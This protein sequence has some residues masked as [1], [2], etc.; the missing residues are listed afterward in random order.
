[1]APGT[2]W[3]VAAVNLVRYLHVTKVGYC[4]TCL[5][6]WW[7]LMKGFA[8]WEF[9]LFV[10]A[11]IGGCDGGSSGCGVGGVRVG[12]SKKHEVYWCSHGHLFVIKQ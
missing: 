6:N 7:L 9:F 12:A 10:V 5:S 3:L 2:D 11:V 4:L 1:M 8:F